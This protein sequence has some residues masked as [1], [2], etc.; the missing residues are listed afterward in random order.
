MK[1]ADKIRGLSNDE[2]AK[3]MLHIDLTDIDIPDIDIP[4]CSDACEHYK[5]GCY[6]YCPDE[7]R[8]GFIRE[9]LEQDVD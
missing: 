2:L 6:L 9:W 1:I 8:E 4:D 5:L 7:R 3:L